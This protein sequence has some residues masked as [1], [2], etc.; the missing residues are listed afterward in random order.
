MAAWQSVRL[1]LADL[2]NDL[3]MALVCNVLWLLG[4]LLVIPGPPATLALFFYANRLAHGERADLSDF[5]TG[6]RR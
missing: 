6:F 2:W 5:W 4:M 3:W 1:A